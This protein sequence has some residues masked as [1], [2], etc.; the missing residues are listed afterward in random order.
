[1]IFPEQRPWDAPNATTNRALGVLRKT[2]GLCD[3]VIRQ[4][5]AALPDPLRT[6]AGYHFGWCDPNGLPV[7]SESGKALRSALTLGVATAYDARNLCTIDAAA[8]VELVHNFTLVHDDVMDGDPIR[9]GRPTVWKVWGV[10]DAILL[11]DVFHS[12]AGTVLANRATDSMACR[13]SARLRAVELE[14]C[15]GQ[16]LDCAF[17]HRIDVDVDDYVAMAMGKTGA[18]IGCACAL[19]ALYAGAASDDVD[20]VDLF[21][22]ELG[23]AFQFVDDLIGIWGDSSVTGKPTDGDLTRRKR[24]LPVVAALQASGDAAAELADLFASPDP[25]SAADV[26]R[27]TTLI[28]KAG[29]RDIA[30][31]MAQNQIRRSL[32]LLPAQ[33]A[34]ADMLALIQLVLERD[35]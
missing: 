4:N 7:S 20:E 5:V 3:L 11:G 16:Q 6:M 28:E 25:M 31:A 12:L 33:V 9:R 35:R 15:K 17:E 22:R 10:S 1:M 8:A 29:G 13:A 19:G 2:R 32:T 24:T 27:A 14:L 18:L 30:V 34:S 21:G 23:L 26:A